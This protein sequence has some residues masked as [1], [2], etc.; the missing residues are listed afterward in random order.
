MPFLQNVYSLAD[1]VGVIFHPKVGSFS[2]SG[3]VGLGSISFEKTVTRTVLDVAGD[4]TIM[5][6]ALPGNNGTIHIDVQ[7]VSPMHGY[8]TA[9]ANGLYSAQS[10]G[11]VSTWNLATLNFTSIVDGSTHYAVGVSPLK[12]PTKAYGAQGAHLTWDLLATDLTSITPY[13][14]SI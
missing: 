13:I 1:I 10:V 9:W 12:E 4:G 7:Q 8:L 14:L 3:E 5:T 2:F 6:S 11:D